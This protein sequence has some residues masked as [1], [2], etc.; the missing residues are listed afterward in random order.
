[1]TP[2]DAENPHNEA[3][4]DKS[5]GQDLQ[6]LFAEG[7]ACIATQKN[8]NL[9]QDL[10]TRTL[11]TREQDIISQRVALQR[12]LF[13]EYEKR[14]M[15]RKIQELRE[16]CPQISEA[17]AA[18]ALE[19]CNGSED[20]AAAELVG[21]PAFRSRVMGPAHGSSA[22]STAGQKSQQPWAAK[23]DPAVRPKLVDPGSLNHS[24]FVGAF[25]GKGYPSAGPGCKTTLSTLWARS[26]AATVPS[27]GDV[28]DPEG[29]RG[30]LQDGSA[31]GEDAADS[32][33]TVSDG[34]GE[35]TAVQATDGS[36]ALDAGNITPMPQAP[37]HD[38]GASGNLGD[39]GADGALQY[40]LA[41]E[42]HGKLRAARDSELKAAR[43]GSSG[44][45][46]C[47]AVQS[48]PEPMP[49]PVQGVAERRDSGLAR[50]PSPAASRDAGGAAG[51]AG[52]GP[53]AAPRRSPRRC[54]A[55]KA[56]ALAV[57]LA[58]GS[59]EEFWGQ[60]GAGRGSGRGAGARPEAVGRGGRRRR[61]DA[62]GE[63]EAQSSA[64]PSPARKRTRGA[65]GPGSGEAGDSGMPP[66]TGPP[67][68]SSSDAEGERGADSE[69][70]LTDGGGERGARAAGG[71]PAAAS[72]ALRRSG[73][74]R[75]ASPPPAQRGRGDA[76]GAPP[77]AGVRAV[78]ASGHTNRGRVK[79]KSHK[80]AELVD[81]GVLWP[82]RGWHNAGYI[83]PLGFVSRTLFRS[84]VALDQLCVHDCYVQGEGGEHWPGPTFRVV[85]RDRPDEP[86]VAKSCTGCWT[87]VLKRINAEIEARRAAGE[88][89]PPPP[90]TAIA[91]PEYFGLNQTNIQEAVEALDPHHLCVEYWAGKEQRCRAAAGLPAQP[92]PPP[93]RA[94]RA[95]GPRPA[96]HGRRRAGREDPDGTADD[97]AE[98]EAGYAS[99][100]S[101][102]NRSERYRKRR[103][104][105]G[106]DVTALDEDNPL[107]DLLDPITLEPVVRPAISPYGHVMG[108]ATW[109]AVLSESKT[110]PFTKQPLTWESCKVLTKHNI[111]LHADRII[112]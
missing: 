97:E 111:H 58:D 42:S 41:V 15:V 43:H 25:R 78:S 92:G 70:T 54:R 109:K 104:E 3:A 8:D 106:D 61:P 88:D 49:S 12:R 89:L 73:R 98:E 44:V 46:Q 71:R 4:M 65:G 27:T 18:R 56:A 77:P 81:V 60:E 20:E 36:T 62:V 108:M 11:T 6:S 72:P 63:S 102:I 35:A 112:R 66:S 90:K 13:E 24:V 22:P 68:P 105:A 87:G 95:A 86:L 50:E 99:K 107:P 110:C 9:F 31:G 45:S 94:G 29:N 57:F 75:P 34:E 103:E 64:P 85:A 7:I 74:A 76:R 52:D 26:L 53:E 32:D 51:A 19:L 21:N 16:V 33:A 47:D 69:T 82:E 59:D 96:Q 30:A 83:F 55:A 40:R 10:E 37:A 101:G 80:S 93:A 48:G 1:M 84:S 2:N 28:S 23:P 17:A 39:E 14:E 91:G 38:A 67:P 79:Q 5:A 100:W